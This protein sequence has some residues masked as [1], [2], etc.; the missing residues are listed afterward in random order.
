MQLL[1]VSNGISKLSLSTYDRRP[2]KVVLALSSA[3]GSA[4]P[5]CVSPFLQEVSSEVQQA[6]PTAQ[7]LEQYATSHWEVTAMAALFQPMTVCIV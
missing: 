4:S 6:A 2:C 7:Q 1:L 3:N 5:A